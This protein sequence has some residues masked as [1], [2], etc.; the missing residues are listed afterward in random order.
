MGQFPVST[1]EH[2]F[3]ESSISLFAVTFILFI[4]YTVCKA[5]ANKKSMF[6]LEPNADVH[7]LILNFLRVVEIDLAPSLFIYYISM[8]LG[9]FFIFSA[10]FAYFLFISAGLL[11]LAYQ[12]KLYKMIIILRILVVIFTIGAFFDIFIDNMVF[13]DAHPDFIEAF[14]H[15][16]PPG[17]SSLPPPP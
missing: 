9:E 14:A 2:L 16:G 6:G 13:S 3:K 1:E 5:I 10:V 11:I 7:L 8:G 4:A 17:N 12:K 15:G